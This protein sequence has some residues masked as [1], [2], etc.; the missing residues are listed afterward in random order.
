MLDTCTIEERWSGVNDMIERWLEERQSLIVDFCAIG[1]IHENDTDE[2]R[3]EHLQ[4]FCQILIDYAC[5]GHFEVYYQLLREAE[6][7]KDGS[8]KI[9][10]A[11]LPELNENTS[12]LMVFTDIYAE[13]DSDTDFSP[14]ANQLSKLG[15]LLEL[16]FEIEDRLID[17]MHNAHKELVTSEA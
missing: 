11:L 4:Q 7:F 5:A 9:A 1:G 10:Q 17:V 13:A 15:E 3:H 16:R 8:A 14:L 2:K 12:S 6:E